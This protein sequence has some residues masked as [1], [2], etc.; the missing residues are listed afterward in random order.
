MSKHASTKLG[1]AV[2]T[3]VVAAAGVM[4]MGSTGAGAAP[5]AA[6]SGSMAQIQA[7][8]ASAISKRIDS[9][10]AA[11]SRTQGA[12]ALGSDSAAL[13]AYLQ[14]DV[15]PLQ[16]LGAKIAA[17]TTVSDARANAKDIFV[18]YRVYALVLPAARQAARADGVTVT[19][20]PR[21]TSL[22]TRAQSY[23]TSTNQATLQP[24]INSLNNDISGATSAVSGVTNTVLAYTPPQWNANHSL[25]STT[26]ASL[27]TAAA[28]LKSAR[29]EARQIRRY[30][31]SSRT[32]LRRGAQVTPTTDQ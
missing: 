31:R 24:M 22:S 9:L 20:V 28:D 32:S 16:N 12:R 25:L 14:A 1:G 6:S 3:S 19:T 4:A 17:D 7:R 26:K 15:T 8:A 18:D 11:V 29:G 2:L 27:E 13:V 30:L 10:N 5:P 23:V 21:L